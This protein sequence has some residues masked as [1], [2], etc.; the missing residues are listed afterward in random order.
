MW[1][2]RACWKVREGA[3][4]GWLMPEDDGGSCMCQTR[5]LLG[6]L[7]PSNSPHS[8]SEAPPMLARWQSLYQSYAASNP[9]RKMRS[10]RG[11]RRGLVGVEGL[12]FPRQVPQKGDLSGGWVTSMA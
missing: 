3:G 10:P 9:T 6:S 7:A 4:R 12:A 2:R 11:K 1:L 8:H 5:P